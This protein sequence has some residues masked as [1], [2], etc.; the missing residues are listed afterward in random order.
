M[1]KSDNAPAEMP[2]GLVLKV[3]GHRTWM[4]LIACTSDIQRAAQTM[5]AKLLTDTFEA[6]YAL[7]GTVLV[8]VPA[9]WLVPGAPAE[10]DWTKQESFDWLQREA[11]DELTSWL[12]DSSAKKKPAR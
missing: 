2:A 6:L 10:I 8:S 7:I 4:R 11:F 12:V 5:D 9:E 1:A 3:I